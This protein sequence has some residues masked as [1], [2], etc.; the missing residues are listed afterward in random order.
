MKIMLQGRFLEMLRRSLRYCDI[1]ACRR[2]NG[3]RTALGQRL[4]GD[5]AID[6]ALLLGLRSAR[7]RCRAL[8]R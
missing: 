2:I 7:S 3:C 8:L 6:L 1:F 4:N 5:P